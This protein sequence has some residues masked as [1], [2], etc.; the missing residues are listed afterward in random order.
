MILV[1]ALGHI[2]VCPLINLKLRFRLGCL[3]CSKKLLMLH[4]RICISISYI[5]WLVS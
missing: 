1:Q 3:L 4:C 5:R 2:H